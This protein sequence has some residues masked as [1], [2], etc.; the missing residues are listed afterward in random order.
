MSA[1]KFIVPALA[2][3]GRAA[4]KHNDATHISWAAR[5]GDLTS[6]QLNVAPQP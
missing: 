3:A 4:G 5:D 1:I 6:H 2:I